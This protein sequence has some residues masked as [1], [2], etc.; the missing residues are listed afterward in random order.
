MKQLFPHEREQKRQAL[1][2]AVQQVQD[3]L[4]ADVEEAE[5]LRTLPSTSVLALRDSGLLA[6]KT[7]T[8]LGGAEADPLIQIEII[9]A[10]S[11][12]SPSAGWY[13]FI[14]A[15]T[16]GLSGAFLPEAAV[17]E[18]FGGEHFPLVTGG[19]GFRPGELVPIKGGYRL[20]GRWSW[21][22]GIRHAEWLNILGRINE[23]SA[24]GTSEIR[25][26]VVPA[27]SVEIH[28]NWHVI[29]L[30]GTGS[31][32]FSATD[33]FVPEHFTHGEFGRESPK[34][35]GALYRLGIPALLA[36]ENAA[37]SLGVA[38]RAL[39]E[40]VAL[41]Q[42]KLRGYGK[43]T[44]LA[45]RGVFQRAVGEGTLRLRA[46]RA[47]LIEAYD[48]AWATAC[49]GEKLELKTQAEL[50][51][52]SALVSDIAV[53][54]ATDA[55]AYGA[56]TA[57]KLDSFL[58]RCFRDLHTADTHFLASDSS[59]ENYGQFLLGLPDADPLA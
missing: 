7:P 43:R 55:F 45:Q 36:N 25:I 33:V 19:G 39:D 8:E 52:A 28:D 5:R 31:C 35:G 38:R 44:M 51:A 10:V 1:L 2:G 29:G 3:I 27:R 22:S 9:E 23:E 48:R 54:V 30:S 47:L 16:A 56:G 14:G 57:I 42:S 37:F 59:Y 53:K 15:A 58:Q 12:I 32:D 17:A 13:L 50:R 49:K 40:V 4:A 26:C 34:R 20:T 6:L 21:G 41:A 11:Y 18:I 24:G 46:A